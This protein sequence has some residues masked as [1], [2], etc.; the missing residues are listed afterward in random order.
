M[1]MPKK[2]T[3]SFVDCLFK[4]ALSLWR[5]YLFDRSRESSRSD[6]TEFL[7]ERLLSS[8]SWMVLGTTIHGCRSI[9]TAVVFVKG[10]KNNKTRTGDQAMIS[11]LIIS[12]WFWMRKT[13]PP[14]ATCLRSG[15]KAF[16]DDQWLMIYLFRR[17][18]APK[19]KSFCCCFFPHLHLFR[20]NANVDNHGSS[21]EK[22]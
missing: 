16:G 10:H 3:N 1:K 2:H 12:N 22:S 6:A 5:E 8:W 15:K 18:V 9:W 4:K 11:I 17:R 14:G 20:A 7:C 21:G 19:K 13:M